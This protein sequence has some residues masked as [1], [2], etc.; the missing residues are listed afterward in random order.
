MLFFFTN[1]QK[2]CMMIGFA[3]Y[4]KETRGNYLARGKNLFC[5]SATLLLF[6]Y[7]SSAELGSMSARKEITLT[8]AK[9]LKR[10]S[11]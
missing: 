9:S 2:K 1:E 3:S 7:C 8:E 6:R 11:G 10:L 5:K 4:L